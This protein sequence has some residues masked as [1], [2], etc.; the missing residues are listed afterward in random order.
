MIV[1]PILMTLEPSP[2]CGAGGLRG[3]YDAEN[4]DIELFMKRVLSYTFERGEVI[5]TGVVND[6]I[7]ASVILYGRIDESLGLGSF[8]DISLHGNG[9]AA[10]R[11][12]G[13]YDGIRARLTGC[14]ADYDGCAFRGQR[15]RDSGSNSF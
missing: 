1:E 10:R 12:N 11:I 5:D 14:I 13:V 15:F 9:L 8:G 2:K 6:N 7:E 4:V 3:K